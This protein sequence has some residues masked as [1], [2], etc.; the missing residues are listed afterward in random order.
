MEALPKIKL[1]NSKIKSYRWVRFRNQKVLLPKRN[2]KIQNIAAK[3]DG[4]LDSSFINLSSSKRRQEED[5]TKENKTKGLSG[6]T[7]LR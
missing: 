7:Y 1:F 2:Q 3:D 4:L 5:I 6:L